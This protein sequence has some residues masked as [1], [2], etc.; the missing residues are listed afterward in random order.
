MGCDSTQKK[1]LVVPVDVS[2]H[3]PTWGATKLIPSYYE[4]HLMFQ[5]THPH[6]VRL[7]H[8]GKTVNVLKFQSTHPHGVRRAGSLTSFACSEVSIHAPTWGAT[9][10]K[11]DCLTKEPVS[12]HA[13]TWGATRREPKARRADAFQSTHPHGVRPYV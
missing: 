6:G 3:A 13:P 10:S 7:T 1:A 4:W 2:I 9:P 8:R 11:R 12:I 5:S